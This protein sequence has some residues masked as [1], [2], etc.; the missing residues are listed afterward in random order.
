[1]PLSSDTRSKILTHTDSFAHLFSL[2]CPGVL[3]PLKALNT[4]MF[5]SGCMNV[6]FKKPFHCDCIYIPY[7]GPQKCFRTLARHL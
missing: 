2:V 6:S 3:A 5:A 4:R 7:L 1:M